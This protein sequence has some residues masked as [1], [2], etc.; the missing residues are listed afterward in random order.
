MNL[1]SDTTIDGTPY[2]AAT[3]EH[4][5]WDTDTSAVVVG[6]G[7]DDADDSGAID[8]AEAV[9]P[10]ATG[11][12]TGELQTP[13]S[14][15][16]VG[17]NPEAIYADWNL[18]LDDDLNTG[19]PT[20]G[21]DD[22][23]D[24]G[25]TSQYPVL[26]ADFNGDSSINAG[27]IN[28]QR[29]S[30]RG[31]RG[32]RGDGGVSSGGGGGGGG[33]GSSGGGGGSSRGGGGPPPAPPRSPIIGSTSAATAME[34]AGDLLVLQRHD[35]PGVEV[36]VGVGWISRD[37]QTIIVIGFVRDGDLGQTYAVVRREGDGQGRAA[38]D[39]ARQPLGLRGALGHREH[40]VHLPG[41]GDL[42]DPAG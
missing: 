34:L 31:G 13:R 30:G 33:G 5:Y 4:S 39:C 28:L 41:G 40:A 16:D 32:G 36:E 14:Y 10:G 24:F 22:P 38:L 17:S 21:G 15:T 37:G 26:K 27:D 12:T 23:W 8:G 20:T 18:N 11:K 6:I 1:E 2:T 9:Q 35:Q 25:T 3:V 7:N 29:S 19:D 42:G